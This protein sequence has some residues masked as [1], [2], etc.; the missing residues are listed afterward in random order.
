MIL[1]TCALLFLARGDRR[2]SKAARERLERAPARCFC[3][4]SSF[5]IALRHEQGKLHLPFKPLR[6]LRELEGRYG[7]TEIPLDSALCIAAA[8]LP[9]HHRDPFDRFIIAAALRLRMP[10]VTIDPK[11]APY[12][13]ETLA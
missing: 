12:G 2:L 10:V 1:D 6:W 3:A 7:L 9:H 5:E 13:V 4:I 11:F 8:D